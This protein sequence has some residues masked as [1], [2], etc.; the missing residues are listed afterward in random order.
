MSAV[1]LAKAGEPFWTTKPPGRGM[2]LGLFL[3][4]ATLEQIGGRFDLQAA[5]AKGATATM[6]VPVVSDSI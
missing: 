1:E 2:G 4:R 3:V 6:T 5:P